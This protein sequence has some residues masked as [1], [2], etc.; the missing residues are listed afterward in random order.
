[1]SD[2]ATGHSYYRREPMVRRTRFAWPNGAQ[3]ACAIVVCAEYYEM[4]PPADAFIPPNVPGGFGRGPYPDFRN[5]SA[6]AYGNRVGIFRIFEALDRHGIKASVALDALTAEHCP[7]L[8]PHI[9]RRDYEIVAHGQSVTR[10]ISSHMS[11]AEERRYIRV[12]LDTIKAATGNVPL[13]WH[14]PEYGESARTPA[15]LAEHG[16][17][18]VLDWPNDEQPIGLATPHGAVT[19]LP[20]LIDLD[21]VYAQFQRKISAA[22]W[23]MCVMDA[24]QQMIEDG[25]DGI[26]RM[27]VINLHPWL[28]GHPFRMEQIE[29]LF[30][31]LAKQRNIWLTTTGEIAALWASH[32]PGRA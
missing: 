16:V 6:R 30:G 26:A 10:V 5:Y 15:L 7:Q 22:R 31:S 3:A 27:L 9:A 19:S 24:L 13:G 14:G 18:Y 12:S 28:S 2:A 23:R 21:D 17:K 32:W 8:L 11:E 4:Q 1:M 25:Q 20:M 29:A